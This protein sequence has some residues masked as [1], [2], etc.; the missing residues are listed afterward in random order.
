MAV[1][2]AV[3][4]YGT[5]NAQ[6]PY[7]AENNGNLPAISATYPSSQVQLASFP[8]ADTNVFAIQPGAIMSNGV[9]CY[10]VVEVPPSGLQIYSTKYVVKETVATLA[11]LRNA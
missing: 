9:Y 7:A 4:V 11:T 10:G 5:V 6:P 3:R 8:T 2:F 1:T